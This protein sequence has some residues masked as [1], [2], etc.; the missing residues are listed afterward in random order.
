MQ[1]NP[2]CENYHNINTA[3]RSSCPNQ[4]CFWQREKNK[5]AIP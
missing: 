3:E 4:Y 1:D 5:G 2:D